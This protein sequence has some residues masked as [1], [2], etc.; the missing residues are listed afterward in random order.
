MKSHLGN[1]FL[2]FVKRQKLLLTRD[3]VLIA[4]SGGVDSLV[5]L[6]LLHKYSRGLKISVGVVHLNHQ[7][8]SGSA[9]ADQKL[10]A[11]IC[12]QKG[13]PFYVRKARVRQFAHQHDLSL[14]EAGHKLRFEYF[15]KMAEE[16][17]YNKI[18]TGHHLD[19]QAETI[20]MR[21]ISGTGL[22]GLA[23]IRLRKGKWI[24]PLLFA[25]RSQILDYAREYNIAHR[26][27]ETN[28]DTDILR[29]KIRH[30]LLPLLAQEYNRNVKEH[31]IHLGTIS[32]EWDRYI[33]LELPELLSTY[34]NVITQ[35]KIEV[36]ISFFRQYFSGIKIRLIEAILSRLTDREVKTGFHKIN[37]FT[38]WLEK[39]KP[40]SR[41]QWD[42][43]VYSLKSEN[44]VEFLKIVSDPEYSEIIEIKT[45]KNYRLPGTGLI[46]SLQECG[47][48]EIVFTH[49]H[50]VEFIEG[51]R[52]QF[53]VQ[54]RGWR[55]GDRFLPLGFNHEKLVS[56][57]LTDRKIGFPERDRVK[58]LLNQGEIMAIV[59]VQISERYKVRQNSVSIYKLKL[60]TTE[61]GT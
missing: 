28:L 36:G 10:V 47:R 27:D 9:E 60:E 55:A 41:F 2:E 16:N 6:H 39:G 12:R 48:E 46:L 22:Q 58:V 15:E 38:N 30:R 1:Q 43:T 5:L 26:E 23:G 7:I 35:N 21:L 40:G 56:D 25:D 29:N 49:D 33:Q 59:G 57:Y 45:G 31:L 53:P 13:I 8:R 18:A 4:V 44:N 34:V 19:D 17:R 52:L 50:M 3:K 14:E 51:G 11:G 42:N 32:E 37:D 54:L 61:N 24:R 20:L